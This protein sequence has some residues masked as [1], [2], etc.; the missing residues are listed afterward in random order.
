MSERERE[1]DRNERMRAKVKMR[2]CKVMLERMKN[3]KRG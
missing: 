1:R 2:N 3:N